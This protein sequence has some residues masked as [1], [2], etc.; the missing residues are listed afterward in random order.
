MRLLHDREPALEVANESLRL[1]QAMWHSGQRPCG[2]SAGWI[3][4]MNQ[5]LTYGWVGAA[6]LKDLYFFRG[7]LLVRRVAIRIS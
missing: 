6:G 4:L 7:A 3:S 1:S 2:S 5:P